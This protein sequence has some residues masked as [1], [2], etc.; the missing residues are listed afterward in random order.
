MK[1]KL[2]LS[3]F[4]SF[5]VYVSYS[6]VPQGINYQAVAR[7]SSGLPIMNTTIQVKM[8]ILSD[9]ITP[10]IVWEE[11]HSKVKTN[12][13]GAFNLVVGTGVWQTGSAL[14]FSDIEWTA[15]PLFLKVQINYLGTWT[16][17]GSTRLWTV[18]YAMASGK[19]VGPVKKLAVEGETD[20]MEEAL[21]EVKNKV[22]QTVFAVYNEG[23]RIYVDNGDAKGAKGGFAVGGFGD[24]KALSQEYFV[25]TGDSI[26]AYIYDD[27]LVKGAKGGFAVGGFGDSKELTNDYLLISPDSVRIYVE[28]RP[29]GKGAKGGFAVGGFGE[30]KASTVKLMHLTRDNYF[31]G[32]EAGINNT[33]GKFNSFIGYQAGKTNINGDYNI[34]IGYQSGYK[35]LGPSGAVGGED[36]SFNCYLGYQ[37]GFENLYGGHNTMIGYTSGKNN[38][39]SNN[40]FL[41]SESGS[42]N[43]TGYSNTFVGM[44][45]GWKNATGGYNVFLGREAGNNV[46]N[47]SWNT[48]IGMGA[49][50]NLLSGHQN[51]VIGTNAMGE[52][53]FAGSGTGSSNIIIGFQAGYSAHNSSS[54]IFIGNQAGYAETG[55]NLLYI[56]N[57]PDNTPLVYGN[58]ESK[59]F[60][61]NGDIEY[62]GTI[63]P[64]S[65]IRLKK[66]IT[67]LEN[68]IEKL[69]K[70]KGVYYEWNLSDNLGLLL[71]EGKQI[72]V[73]AQDVESVYPELVTTNDKGY[74]MVDYT[75]LTPVLLEAIKEQQKMIDSQN[76]KIERLEN[77]VEQ[78][79]S[80]NE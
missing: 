35:H 52:N 68:V 65:D 70:I 8:G 30:S 42:D 72:G 16:Y 6:Q 38:T 31:I 59:D 77:L 48:F 12:L 13:T 55:S 51:V 17:L 54:N 58:F 71:R 61:I 46:V 66:N 27:P 74:K 60:R 64:P 9:T 10:V 5:I 78:L 15:G 7:N 76:S 2:F 50:A 39:S 62:T 22:G 26:R 20:N 75:K 63:G 47:G 1:P 37:T 45:A 14:S 40:T 49:G 33:T 25:V 11:L 80:Q 56:N 29:S 41:G 44:R 21:F 18:P 67:G 57:K 73:I 23:V 53:L 79:L 3:S 28:N 19:T 43:T 34:L 69:N 32:H 4:L 24:S 36:G